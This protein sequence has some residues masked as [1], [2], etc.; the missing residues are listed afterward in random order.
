M[1]NELITCPYC[2]AHK[3]F[4]VVGSHDPMANTGVLYCAKCGGKI[5]DW[6]LVE[7]MG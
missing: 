5:G 3:K 4:Q 1:P 7:R 6:S 2:G